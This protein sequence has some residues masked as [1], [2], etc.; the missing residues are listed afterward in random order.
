MKGKTSDA[1]VYINCESKATFLSDYLF[2]I[3]HAYF[4]KAFYLSAKFFKRTGIHQRIIRTSFDT[5]N[6]LFIALEFQL[7]R[8][9]AEIRFFPE[10]LQYYL[11]Y[12]HTRLRKSMKTLRQAIKL[13]F[14]AKKKLMNSLLA[15]EGTTEE[16][17]DPPQDSPA[18]SFW[19]LL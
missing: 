5:R 3:L 17:R 2:Y 13:N 7:R 10:Y 9:R 6:D 14:Y 1:R 16:E 4:T 19:R 15:I 11:Q 18:S 8:I 12:I